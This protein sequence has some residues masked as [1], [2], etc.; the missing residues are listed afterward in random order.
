[1]RVNGEKLHEMDL[2][3]AEYASRSVPG[4]TLYG[5]EMKI[6]TEKNLLEIL[7]SRVQRRQG[8]YKLY[9]LCRS[10]L[11]FHLRNKARI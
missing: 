1:M 7:S 10:V 8:L 2:N 5:D 4:P 11:K 9:P 6:H 3:D